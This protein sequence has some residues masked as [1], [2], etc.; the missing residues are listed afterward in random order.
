VLAMPACRG[1]PLS[2]TTKAARKR[3]GG[4]SHRPVRATARMKHHQYPMQLRTSAFGYQPL[5]AAYHPSRLEPRVP[6]PPA[7]V[8]Y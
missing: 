5:H 4:S 3:D 6:S 7:V 1:M 2:V 8:V